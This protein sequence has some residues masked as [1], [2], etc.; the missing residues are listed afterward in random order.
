M[1]L[2][3]VD[4]KIYNFSDTM[5][6]KGRVCSR[7]FNG[8]LISNTYSIPDSLREFA[9]IQ[10]NLFSVG[11]ALMDIPPRSFG[12]ARRYGRC[13]GVIDANTYANLQLANPNY[14]GS[15]LEWD[16]GTFG[17]LGFGNGNVS[18]SMGYSLLPP[19]DANCP[20]LYGSTDRYID[21]LVNL[22]NCPSV[23]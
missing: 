13:V 9:V 2:E 4:I 11:L 6:Q 14:G 10:G 12:F 15:V 21:I 7:V 23:I 17:R 16:G 3:N 8:T 22:F 5:I 20:V 19:S 18:A 1:T